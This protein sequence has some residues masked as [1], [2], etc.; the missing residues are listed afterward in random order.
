MTSLYFYSITNPVEQSSG[1]TRF[2]SRESQ[3][4]S[5]LQGLYCDPKVSEFRNPRKGFRH[6]KRIATDAAERDSLANAVG[7]K[8]AFME[9]VEVLWK[10]KAD[11]SRGIILGCLFFCFR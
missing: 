6:G 7:A 9:V 4:T 3:K 10:L 1:H 5:L 8:L 11:I 2:E